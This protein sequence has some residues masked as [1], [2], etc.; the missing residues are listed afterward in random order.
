MTK[1][2]Q[3][4]Y[5]HLSILNIIAINW[6]KWKRNWYDPPVHQ[7]IS[8]TKL[9]KE[10]RLKLAKKSKWTFFRWFYF[11]FISLLS[12]SKIIKKKQLIGRLHVHTIFPQHPWRPATFLFSWTSFRWSAEIREPSTQ[13]AITARFTGVA[14]ALKSILCRNSLNCYEFLINFQEVTWYKMAWVITQ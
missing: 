1:L 3:K 5:T 9:E 13:H 12:K 6:M 2:Q 8:T 11:S 7:H 10:F 14:V 4:A